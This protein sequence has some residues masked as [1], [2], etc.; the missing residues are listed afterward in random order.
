MRPITLGITVLL[1]SGGLSGCI[2]SPDRGRGPSGT[3][4]LIYEIPSTPRLALKNLVT[5]YSARDSVEYRKLFDVSYQGGS[6]D[7]S[8]ASGVQPGTFTWIDEVRH[9]QALAEDRQIIRVRLDFGPDGAWV[10]DPVVGPMGELWAE[11]TIYKPYLEVDN[12]TDS[13]LLKPAVIT[14]DFAPQTPAANSPTD[15]LWYIVRW[16][17]DPL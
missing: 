11:I 1:A 9:I 8:D 5:A 10:R 7:T 15:T 6:F 2:F 4:P 12:P 16:R 13:F 3:P 14:F 17:E